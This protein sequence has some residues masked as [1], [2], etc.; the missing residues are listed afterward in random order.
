ME[1]RPRICYL[2]SLL[3]IHGSDCEHCGHRKMCGEEIRKR[4]EELNW[5]TMP[6]SL[7]NNKE[8]HGDL[9]EIS[10]ST[11]EVVADSPAGS[12]DQPEKIA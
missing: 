8:A 4:L 1:L 11:T 12:F 9:V 6:H 5:R 10:D 2:L 7:N 3:R